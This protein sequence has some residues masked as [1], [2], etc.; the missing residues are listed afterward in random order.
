[1]YLKPLRVRN[2]AHCNSMRPRVRRMVISL[3]TFACR[4]NFWVPLIPDGQLVSFCTNACELNT[5]QFG[6]VFLPRRDVI[7]IE[8]IQVRMAAG[9]GHH[10]HQFD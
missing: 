4:P 8:L 5:G 9:T 10:R 2:V 3:I 1:M 7:N 6:H